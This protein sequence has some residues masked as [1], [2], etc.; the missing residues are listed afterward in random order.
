MGKGNVVHAF[1]N[2]CQLCENG[3]QVKLKTK[4][5]SRRPPI[6]SGPELRVSG[7]TPV[8]WLRRKYGCFMPTHP[9]DYLKIEVLFST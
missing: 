4:I 5:R 2:D 8:V 1:F 7:Y 9:E 3:Y 6:D